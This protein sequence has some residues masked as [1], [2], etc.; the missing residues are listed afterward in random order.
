[1]RAARATPASP[2]P[3]RFASTTVLDLPELHGPW[4][5]YPGVFAHGRLDEGTSLLLE[6]LQQL[7]PRGRTLDFA[8][9]CG[10]L[11]AFLG[12]SNPDAEVVLSDDDLLAVS[13]SRAT[14]QANGVDATIIASDGFSGIQGRFDL[15]VSNPPFHQGVDTRQRMGMTLLGPARNFLNPRGQLLVVVNRHLPYPAWIQEQF[16]H[17]HEFLS[18]RRFRVLRA[19]R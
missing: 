13:S 3:T 19:R 4:R 12:I 15:I 11:G 9:G 8:S 18:N 16:A 14:L 2:D 7:G 5:S 17:S 1:A 10:V 6:A